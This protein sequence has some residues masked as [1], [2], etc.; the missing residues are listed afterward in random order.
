MQDMHRAHKPK[1]DL[2]TIT[3][4]GLR[5]MTLPSLPSTSRSF[6]EFVTFA[7]TAGLF[8]CCRKASGLAVLNMR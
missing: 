2:S 4:V 5:I 1:E 7:Q 6:V 3:P 8:A